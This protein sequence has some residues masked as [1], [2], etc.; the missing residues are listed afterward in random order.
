MCLMFINT[1]LVLICAVQLYSLRTSP[2]LAK[3]LF[4]VLHSVAHFASGVI[5]EA[6]LK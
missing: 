5:N 3:L 6:S 1:N 2:Q 4:F